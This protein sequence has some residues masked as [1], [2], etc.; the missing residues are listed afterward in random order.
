MKGHPRYIVSCNGDVLCWDWKLTGKPRLCRLSDSGKGYLK[1]IIDGVK[2]YVHRLV[3]EA[4][5]PN[6]NNKP[7][8]DHV[9]TNRQNNCVWNLCWCTSKENSNNPITKK[10]RSEYFYGN[11]YGKQHKWSKH[12]RS[13]KIV[14]LTMNGEF[15]KKWSCSREAERELGIHHQS[16]IQCCLGK[17]KSAGGYRWMYY[18]EWVK[19]Q[20]KKPQDIKPLF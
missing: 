14:Q 18:S 8:V 20:R 10:R 7:E 17:Y 11:F 3:A 1:V 5:I 15:I 16:I 12:Y 4:F 13:I 9:D 6:T 19:L 2:K